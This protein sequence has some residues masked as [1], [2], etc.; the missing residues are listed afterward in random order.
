MFLHLLLSTIVCA[1]PD[2]GDIL[3][4]LPDVA[5][6]E[7]K[8]VD[9][10]ASYIIHI[11]D[12]HFVDKDTFIADLRDQGITEDLDAKYAKHLADVEQVQAEQMTLLRTL[13]EKHS[14]TDVY[15]EGV[16]ANAG[17]EYERRLITLKQLREKLRLLQKI[18]GEID[19]ADLRQ[20]VKAGEHAL[21]KELLR[22]GAAG[23]LQMDG[24][25]KTLP[26][27]DKQAFEAAR[28]VAPNGR[29]KLDAKLI[30]AREDAIVKNVLARGP[31]SLLVLGGAHDLSNN[32]PK[33]CQYIRVSTKAFEAMLRE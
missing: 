21:R 8:P 10:P 15:V 2:Q 23:Q 30:E 13:V 33:D 11:L 22:V 31:V 5:H 12:W 18:A 29:V 16:T 1:A 27:E 9:S 7:A 25:L 32:V 20:K 26:A 6:V 4:T 3:V 17:P 19:D 28:P 24:L 14:V